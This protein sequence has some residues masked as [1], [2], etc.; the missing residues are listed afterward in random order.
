MQ[1]ALKVMAFEKDRQLPDH[2]IEEAD[3]VIEIAETEYG[4]ILTVRYASSESPDVTGTWHLAETPNPVL[5]TLARDVERAT[6]Q[7]RTAEAASAKASGF[8]SSAGASLRQ[9]G[10]MPRGGRKP[11]KREDDGSTQR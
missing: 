9:L 7:I 1:I 2:V 3:W 11:G 6:E 10:D 4:P 5:R 8:L